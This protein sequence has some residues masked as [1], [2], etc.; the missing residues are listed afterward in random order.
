MYGCYTPKVRVNT[1]TF[2][3][4]LYDK[5][6]YSSKFKSIIVQKYLEGP[7]SYMLLT[8]KQFILIMPQLYF[9]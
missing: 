9:H 6:K 8:K 3:V 7:L 5:I 1:L 2:G 4:F